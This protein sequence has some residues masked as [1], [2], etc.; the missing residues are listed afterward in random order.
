MRLQK[1]V[2]IKDSDTSRTECNSEKGR[3]KKGV[4]YL[5][6]ILQGCMTQPFGSFTES[7]LC[8]MYVAEIRG[9]SQFHE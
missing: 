7:S 6:K 3:E 9:M 8:P 4:R 5:F 2:E 1:S